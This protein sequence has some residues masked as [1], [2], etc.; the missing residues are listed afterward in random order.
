MVIRF[1]DLQLKEGG[2]VGHYPIQ[3]YQKTF[4]H[5]AYRVVTPDKPFGPH[6]HKG[7][8][9]WFILKGK[10]KVNI[11]GEIFDVEENDLIVCPE[12]VSHGMTS[13]GEVHWLCIG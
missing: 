12:G 5:F 4:K 6:S 9:L 1:K 8:E 11:G 2:T 7:D 3:G 10:A 13:D